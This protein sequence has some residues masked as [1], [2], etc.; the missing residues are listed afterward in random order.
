MKTDSRF[1]TVYWSEWNSD[2]TFLPGY[3]LPAESQGKLYAVLVHAFYGDRMVMA[4]IANR[5][6]CIPSGRLLPEESIDAAAV[7]ET[8]EETGGHL[9]DL[10]RRL[11][12][13][14]RMRRRVEPAAVNGSAVFYS[15]VFVADVTHFEPIPAD[16]ESRGFFLIAPEDVAGQYF[17]WD[18][19]LTEA[20]LYAIEQRALFSPPGV[21]L[22]SKT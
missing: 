13:C 4:D 15:A 2:V 5:G 6:V 3:E 11:I 14:Y 21:S 7:R 1:P 8:Y 19:L 12:G 16:S 10:R 20:F 17:M 18:S 22:D 9:H